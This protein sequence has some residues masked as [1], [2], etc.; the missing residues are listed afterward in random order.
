MDFRTITDTKET[1]KSKN[2]SWS[3]YFLD[4]RIGVNM[5]GGTEKRDQILPNVP[6][7]D[8]GYILPEYDFAG[9]VIPPDYVGVKSGS[10]LGS[11]IDAAKGIIYYSDTIGFGTNSTSMTS[12]LPYKKLGI[13]FFMKSGLTCSNGAQ[14]ATYFEGIPKGDGL[15]KSLQNTMNRMGLP[16]LQGIAPGML[17][18][19]KAAM[20]IKPILQSAFGNVYPVCEQVTKQVGDAWGWTEDINTGDVWIKGA[21]QRKNGIPYQTRWVQKTNRKGEPLYISREEWENT[22]KTHNLDGTP[23]QLAPEKDEEGF[24]TQVKEVNKMSIVLAIV[25]LCGAFAFTFREK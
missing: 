23:K 14:M 21:I 20:N 13:N 7:E 9:N 8:T 25:F 1:I 5:S 24:Q 4:T 3:Y 2:N 10:S 12:G 11:V 16:P 15:G 6:I 18:D 22:P 19:T 17:E